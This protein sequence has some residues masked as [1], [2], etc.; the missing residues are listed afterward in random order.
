MGVLP[1]QFGADVNAK[2]LALDGSETF[3]VTGL[4][5][6]SDKDSKA[7]LIVQRNTGEKVEAYLRVRLDSVVEREYYESGGILDYVLQRTVKA[8]TK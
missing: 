6:I 5:Q 3:S 8:R 2:S 1:L 7:K 4:E